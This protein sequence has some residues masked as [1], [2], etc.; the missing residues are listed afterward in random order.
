MGSGWRRARKALGLRVCTS[1]PRD[2]DDEQPPLVS[3][4]ATSDAEIPTSSPTPRSC[5]KLGR[6][7]TAV[8][9]AGGGSSSNPST[10]K[11]Q[12]ETVSSPTLRCRTGFS[13]SP[14]LSASSPKSSS[15]T[16]SSFFSPR[17]QC[18][19]SKSPRLA[20]L[21]TF[22]Y[23]PRSP[24]RLAILKAS[25]R[26]TRSNSCGIC[27][28]STKSGQ[29]TAIFTA[30]CSHSF[31]FQCISA[32]VQKQR[33]LV[34]PVCQLKWKEVPM[35]PGLMAPLQVP[36]P[37]PAPPQQPP[38]KSP[39]KQ[40]E[41]IRVYDDDEPLAPTNGAG[42]FNPIP[43][44]GEE[45]EQEV[46]AEGG[47]DGEFKG[48]FV[49]GK[50]GYD[51]K[52]RE[53][54]VRVS[55]SPE[56]ALVG[57][58]RGYESYAVVL[59][60]R[61]P[62]SERDPGCR[63]P[64]DLV[65]VLDVSGSISGTK[66][67]MIKRAMRLVISSL[68]SSDRLSIVAFSS[69]SKRL[70]PLRRMTAQGQRAARRVVDRLVCSQGTC[71]SEALRKAAKVLE[72]RRDRNP[73]ASIMLLSDGHDNSTSAAGDD[74]AT[75]PTKTTTTTRFGHVEI[76][77]HAFGLGGSVGVGEDAFAQCVGGLLSV[78]VQDLHLQI[79]WSGCEVDGVYSWPDR[80]RV[81]LNRSGSSR[82]GTIR[83]GDLYAEE[84]REIL[85]EVRVP[86]SAVPG[87]QAISLRSCFRD[88]VSQQP[89]YCREQVLILPGMHPTRTGSIKVDR[90][91]NKFQTTRAAAQAGYLSELGDLGSA[92]QVL[93]AARSAL[94]KSSSS[95]LPADEHLRALESE[96]SQ[97]HW[98]RLHQSQQ[99][100]QPRGVWRQE[101]EWSSSAYADAIDA[102]TP[103]SAWR[104][105][106]RL[107]KVAIL[108]KSMNR[109]SDLHGFE[110]ARF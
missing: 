33:S 41:E 83:L 67:H 79:R 110:N 26:L 25:L 7:K 109:V 73:V 28:H 104:A 16:P 15:S 72:D 27:S 60:V 81:L 55:S 38:P 30:E 70:L 51:E 21:S 100:Q 105:A 8:A 17:L 9:S 91:R 94:L 1:A 69:S 32:Y 102:L 77:V 95:S 29:G 65:T 107:A 74:G 18:K 23:S 6:L 66:L 98:R 35:L 14:S 86:A 92:Q 47:D 45:E 75:P 53:R 61:A 37:Y 20:D 13:F 36:A 46:N 64:I 101:N 85:V 3:S 63:A 97:L 90:L 78:V 10:P 59:R 58:G 34:C 71:V 82:S 52:E 4:A 48:F 99:Q 87:N 42:R 44:V 2:P 106:E 93:A 56:T 31:H 76:P 89:V 5:V 96:L 84:E 19:T 43:E 62:P 50:K 54:I 24:S 80:P 88:P 49:D 108:R 39:R 57:A 103:T 11:L 40:S 12:P 22:S 68:G